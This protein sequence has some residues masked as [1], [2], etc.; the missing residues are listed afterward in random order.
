MLSRLRY[1][2]VA[3]ISR[4]FMNVTKEKEFWL[5]NSSEDPEANIPIKM[6][7]GIEVWKITHCLM[8]RPCCCCCCS[9]L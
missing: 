6:D 9:F 8:I 4:R 5:R 2:L 3:T 1:V 7:V